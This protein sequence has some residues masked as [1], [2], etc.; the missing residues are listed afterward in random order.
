MSATDINISDL[1]PSYLAEG[2]LHLETVLLTVKKE[3]ERERK[4]EGKESVV[5][6][7]LCLFLL[8]L[9]GRHRE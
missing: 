9:C 8:L 1:Y 2:L 6:K 7:P 4:K 5:W 3:T